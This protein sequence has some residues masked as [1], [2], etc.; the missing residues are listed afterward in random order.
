MDSNVTPEIQKVLNTITPDMI[1]PNGEVSG[2]V[3]REI[4]RL[5]ERNRRQKMR[6]EAEAMR[7]A[8]A[9]ADRLAWIVGRAIAESQY[10]EEFQALMAQGVEQSVE[11]EA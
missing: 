7:P 6:A 11:Q 5:R 10:A 3:A 2:D 4:K 1:G 8:L 9:R